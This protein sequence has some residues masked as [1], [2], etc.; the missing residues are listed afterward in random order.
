M[1]VTTL[2]MVFSVAYYSELRNTI[3]P[4]YGVQFLLSNI[5]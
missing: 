3:T 2:S 5:L 4:Y 1:H